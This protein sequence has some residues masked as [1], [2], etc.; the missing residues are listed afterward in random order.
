LAFEWEEEMVMRRFLVL[1]WLVG[2]AG[3]A[4]PAGAAPA[5]EKPVRVLLATGVDYKGHLWKKTAPA[6]RDVLEKDKRLEVRIVDDMEF[7]ASDALF[8]Y[9]VLLL[10]LKNY[11][12]PK[13]ADG[14]QA[15]LT[16]F[17][18]QGRGLVLFHFACGAFEQ[19]DGFI[20]LAG[21]VWDKTKRAHDPRGPFAVRIVDREHPITRGLEDFQITDE[22]YTCLRGDRP[23]RTL[24]AARSKID[25]NDYPM[26]FVLD[27]GRGRVFHTVL[28]H[29][30]E[31]IGAPGLDQLLQRACL[32]AAGRQP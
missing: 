32:W 20:E 7:L 23:I 11:D 22:L 26:A 12:A 9:D 2:A 31:A 5:E 8:D 24:A 14:V 28:G 21:R 1:A 6:L 19:W 18:Q 16:R 17:V 13:R 10:H 4:A 3:L 30:V 25:G 29:D 15:N 27:C